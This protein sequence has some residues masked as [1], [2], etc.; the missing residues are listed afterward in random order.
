MLLFFLRFGQMNDEER[1][2]N[3]AARSQ[4]RGSERESSVSA[5]TKKSMPNVSAELAS[6]I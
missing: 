3:K 2:E 5:T 1:Q 6:C 4:I